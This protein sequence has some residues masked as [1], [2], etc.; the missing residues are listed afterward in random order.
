[1]LN[2]LQLVKY[3]R[4]TIFSEEVVDYFRT[5]VKDVMEFRRNSGEVHKDFIQLLMELKEKYS[6]D[7]HQGNEFSTTSK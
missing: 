2:K 6:F 5:T 7:D 1:M 4:L 3:L